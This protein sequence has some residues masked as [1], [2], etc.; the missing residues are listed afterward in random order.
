MTAKVGAASAVEPRTVEMSGTTMTPASSAGTQKVS[1]FA[2]RAGFVIPKNKLSGSL[3]PVFRGSKTLG[4]GDALSGESKKQIQRKT[5]WGPD[6]TQ[7][8]S[9]KKGRALA[10]QVPLL[11]DITACLVVQILSRLGWI[12]LHKRLKSGMLEDEN[13]EDL[14][15]APQDLHHKSKSSKHE[16]DKKLELEK[17]EAIDEGIS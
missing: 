7:D 14:L 6:L 8:A 16:I 15:S 11:S 5:K 12:K 3:V 4:A 9:V 13:D 2:A 10:Y 1:M 17:R